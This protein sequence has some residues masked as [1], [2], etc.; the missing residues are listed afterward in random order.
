VVTAGAIAVGN[1]ISR[2]RVR[3]RQQIL[4]ELHSPVECEALHAAKV[5][6]ICTQL[7][8]HPMSR[9]V[10][11]R[12]HAPPHQVPKRRDLR[13][14]DDKID[15]SDLTA[16]IDVDPAT[17]TCT[18]ESG[19]AFDDLVAATLRYNLVPVVVPELKS[20][21]VGGAVSGCS[22]E[23]MSFRYGGFHDSCIAYEVITASGELLECSPTLHP[24]VFQMMHGSFGTLGILTK[25][26]F[27][28][29]PAKPFVHVV[30]ESYGTL[31][32]YRA[33]I[34]RHYRDGDVDFMDGIIHSADEYVLSVANFVDSAPYTHR[35]DWLRVYYKSTR[36]RFDDFLTTPD[37]LF[38]YDRGVTNVMPKSF[39]G[40][41]LLGKLLDSDLLLRTVDRFRQLADDEH[42]TIILD[43][44]LPLSK[45]NEFMTWY[46]RE[47]GYFPLWVVPYK[48]VRDYEWI[49][50]SFYAQLDDE[51]FIDLAIY[52]MKQPGDKNVH[53]LI[54]EKL[55][56]LGGIKTLISHNYYSRDEFWQTWNKRNYDAVKAI[57]DP[58]NVFRDLYTKTCRA[59]MGLAESTG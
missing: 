5:A 42:P 2:R 12:K 14:F 49:D 55:R 17:R 9:P 35:Y 47:I 48:R 45:V 34:W 56:E 15:I 16:I 4:S 54:E 58:N 44:F 24:L 37:Y 57:T 33:A 18:A 32:E 25:L 39:I 8:A 6:R 28:L 53:R 46:E 21:T 52:G 40:R 36:E 38:R 59:A 31:S 20:I 26:T 30:Y 3:L 19:V 7:R 13:Q 1:L 10:S 23:S 27:K 41:L 51:L 43:V 29:V 50:D 22:I 11:L